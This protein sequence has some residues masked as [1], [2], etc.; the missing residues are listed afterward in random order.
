MPKKTWIEVAKTDVKKC[1]LSGDLAPD[2]S[3]G[4]KLEKLS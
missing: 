2:R 1:N 4:R 3:E